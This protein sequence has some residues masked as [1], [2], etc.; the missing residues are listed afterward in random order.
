MDQIKEFMSMSQW[1]INIQAQKY[2]QEDS[3]LKF[4]LTWIS[5]STKIQLIIL[6]IFQSVIA[7]KMH[8]H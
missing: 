4:L 6:K 1:L 8:Y 5:L 7:V 3:L 2:Q